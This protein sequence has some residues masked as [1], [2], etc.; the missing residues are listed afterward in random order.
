MRSLPSTLRPPLPAAHLVHEDGVE[1][2]CALCG[3]P[4]GEARVGAG[5]GVRRVG[6]VG[7]AAAHAVGANAG[8]HVA[9]GSGKRAGNPHTDSAKW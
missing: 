2:V 1:G 5:H 3:Q 8:G 7:G 6:G 9:W 4:G